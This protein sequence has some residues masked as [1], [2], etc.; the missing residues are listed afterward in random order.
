[1]EGNTKTEQEK[2]AEI[3]AFKSSRDCSK[4]LMEESMENRGRNGRF[5]VIGFAAEVLSIFC[6]VLSVFADNPIVGIVFICACSILTFVVTY[7]CLEGRH[8]AA[9]LFAAVII[10][11]LGIALT[12]YS[13]SQK[14]SD[15]P[16][17]TSPEHTIPEGV[18]QGKLELEFEDFM[19]SYSDSQKNG[20][21]TGSIQ[22]ELIAE[23]ITFESYDYDVKID[24]Y[25][26]ENN[27][28]TFEG[29]PSGHCAINIKFENY[30]LISESF[31]LNKK[32]MQDGIWK[33]C[34]T[35]REETDYNSFAIKILDQLGKPL[36]GDTCDIQLETISEKITGIPIGEDGRLP[37]DFDCKAN[38]N[39]TLILHNDGNDY[40]QNID[41]NTVSGTMQ[42]NFQEVLSQESI[43]EQ[44]YIKQKEETK[45]QAAEAERSETENNPLRLL[46][47][48][49]SIETKLKESGNVIQQFADRLSDEER[50]KTYAISLGQTG[51]YWME[52]NHLNL[53]EDSSAWKIYVTDNDG[54]MYME[55]YSNMNRENTSSPIVGLQPGDYIIYVE[56]YG[57][58]SDAEYQ[59]NFMTIENPAYE[60]EPN[61]EILTA[62]PFPEIQDNQVVTCFGNL[63]SSD[64]VDYYSIQLSTPGVLALK[65]EHEN[66]TEDRYG[67]YITVKDKNSEIFVE[68]ASNWKNISTLSP[69][70]GLE[71][72]TYYIEVRQYDSHNSSVYAL[73]AA[74][75]ES[76]SWETEFNDQVGQSD[77]LEE[78]F[79]KYG[80]SLSG[81]DV[82][83]YLFQC[84]R[85]GNYQ[86]S[87]E[88]KNLTEDKYGW[89]IDILDKNSESLLE[90]E[91][92]SNWNTTLSTVTARMREGE[93]Y[94]ILVR[95]VD[96]TIEDY[97]LKLES[98]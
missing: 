68:F 80:N 9:C 30:N 54:N 78:S 67:W 71:A 81:S 43:K 63:T 42:V 33:K 15:V 90:E 21:I 8:K 89:Q 47:N 37:Y 75:H 59:I 94:Y 12:L 72:G 28:L 20:K 2:R 45:R 77:T 66:L 51:P 91:F 83:Y 82:D 86:L 27:V 57:S 56:S 6:N 74:F 96:Y 98:K 65:F 73:S 16:A 39:L 84:N 79:Y 1:M 60:G 50:Q 93:I 14:S 3:W 69:N 36:S 46:A 87:F 4:Q 23:A 55:F 17:G 76:D 26:L 34:I 97:K 11:V 49:E 70:I 85:T 13:N 58:F 41:I 29:I 32:D 88:H 31:T 5:V 44:E 53:T 92:Y 61:H 38:A 48:K 64:D 24:N 10:G 95:C 25:K 7:I 22:N 18:E 35:L 52:F 40:T 62:Q 19:L